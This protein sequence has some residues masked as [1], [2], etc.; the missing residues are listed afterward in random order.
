MSWKLWRLGALVAIFLSLCVALAGLA[1]G[2]KWPAFLAVLGA[3]LLSHFGAYIKDHPVDSV[4]FESEQT[5]REGLDVTTTKT[6]IVQ[7]TP[8]EK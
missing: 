4:R 3:S 8:H 2:M 7:E 1:A 6:S 5:V